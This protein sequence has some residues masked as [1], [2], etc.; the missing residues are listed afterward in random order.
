MMLEFF[1]LLALERKQKVI[2]FYKI[3]N[4]TV[5]V[6]KNTPSKTEPTI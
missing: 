2:P 1:F 4:I 3:S 5:N 6:K